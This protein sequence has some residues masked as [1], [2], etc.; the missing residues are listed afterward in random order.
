MNEKTSEIT[1]DKTGKKAV[2]AK[3]EERL[4]AK[5]RENMHRRKSQKRARQNTGKDEQ[6]G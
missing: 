6:D 4:R 2:A 5:L 1:P 3:R